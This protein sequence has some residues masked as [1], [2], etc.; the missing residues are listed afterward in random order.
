MGS[1]MFIRDS[2]EGVQEKRGEDSDLGGTMRLG[3]QTCVINQGSL[4]E[5]VYGVTAVRERHRHRY[6]VNN[7]YLDD[8]QTAGLK[9]GGRSE[10]GELVE[11]VEIE[12]HPWFLACQFHP[13][14]TSNPRQGHPL[15]VGFIE[16]GLKA[17]ELSK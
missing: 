8:L 10:D 14:F 15:F 3:E 2:R 11:M 16:A 4:A 1:E 17:S 7:N 5:R 9:V 12:D 6:E 13:E